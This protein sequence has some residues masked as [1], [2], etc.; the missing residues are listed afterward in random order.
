MLWLQ[1]FFCSFLRLSF[2]LIKNE[3][4]PKKEVAEIYVCDLIIVA[5]MKITEHCMIALSEFALL[6]SW[7][8]SVHLIISLFFTYTKNT[9]RTTE[10]KV[11]Q[12]TTGASWICSNEVENWNLIL[13]WST[14]KSSDHWTERQITSKKLLKR[15]KAFMLLQIHQQGGLIRQNNIVFSPF[16][17]EILSDHEKSR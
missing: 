8:L 15:I 1:Y 7:N 6:H 14:T 17:T 11:K 2:S 4:N 16:T 13:A 10:I 3:K 12:K 5:W 9:E